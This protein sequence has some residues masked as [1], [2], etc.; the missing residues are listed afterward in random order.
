MRQPVFIG[1][2][3]DKSIKEVRKE[4]EK[5]V[6]KVVKKNDAASPSFLT[7]LDKIYSPKEKIAK[8][9]VLAYYEKIAPL[10]LP[11]LKDRPESLN[12]SP[13]ESINP[14]SFKRT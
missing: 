9:D 5:K 10:L 4:E 12:D 14:H 1:I 8:G 11:Y 3:R 6:S 7:H 13:M 2:R